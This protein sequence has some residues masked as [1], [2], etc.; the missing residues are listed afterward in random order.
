MSPLVR[1]A[2]TGGGGATTCKGY[3]ITT[4]TNG[5]I[6]TN[7]TRGESGA[8]AACINCVNASGQRLRVNISEKKG[9][10]SRRNCIVVI[11]VSVEAKVFR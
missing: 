1:D 3:R 6:A 5:L 8:V 11:A 10:F 2:T 9:P 7:R 4:G